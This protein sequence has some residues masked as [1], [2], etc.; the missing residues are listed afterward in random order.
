M[1]GTV[2]LPLFD[3][4]SW[5]G[6]A[7]ERYRFLASEL[8]GNKPAFS[9]LPSALSAIVYVERRVRG[10]CIVLSRLRSAVYHNPAPRHSLPPR[11]FNMLRQ[12]GND[13]GEVAPAAEGDWIEL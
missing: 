6:L 11:A 9:K 5:S 7:T 1:P 3:Y 2:I 4:T 10:G 8:L 12:F 13:I